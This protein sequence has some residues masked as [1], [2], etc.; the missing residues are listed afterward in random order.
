MQPT[1]RPTG[2][3]SRSQRTRSH[4]VD[5]ALE[6]FAAKGYPETS[7]EDVCLAAGCS[8]GG[9]YHHFRTKTAI[10]AEVTERLNVLD[11]LAPPLGAFSAATGIPELLL[12]RLMLDL[13]AEAARDPSLAARLQAGRAGDVL[14]MGRLVQGTVF[15]A[16]D[17]E[18]RRAA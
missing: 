3:Q 15:A 14:A 2:Q 11:G 17:E 10:L 5:T 8:K 18:A 12:G 16:Q 4:I 6:V 13:W 7:M 1:N 9:L